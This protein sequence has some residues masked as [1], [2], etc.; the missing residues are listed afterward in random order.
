MLDGPAVP[1]HASLSDF[2]PAA[3]HR[4]I[5]HAGW[6]IAP[7]NLGADGYGV[8]YP[9]CLPYH[10]RVLIAGCDP[11]SIVHRF[12]LAVPRQHTA[13]ARGSSEPGQ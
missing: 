1:V 3:L 12:R 5:L 9:D 7:F 13:P 11:R 2:S 10:G 4:L 8:S 6:H